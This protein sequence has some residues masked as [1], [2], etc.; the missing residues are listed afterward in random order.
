MAF[1]RFTFQTLSVFSAV[2]V[3]TAVLLM[4]LRITSAVSF[5]EPLQL[6][7]SGWEQETLFPIWKSI[8][9]LV[10]YSDPYKIPFAASFY[11]WLFIEIYAT[12][13]G[14]VLSVLSLEDAWLPTVGRFLTL[15]FLFGGTAVAYG[16]FLQFLK[17][18]D[19]A[20]KILSLSFAVFIFFGPLMGFWGFTVRSDIGALLF[21][22]L[23]VYLF[24]KF[25]PSW[26]YQAVLLCAV[27]AYCAWGFKQV[28]VVS[29]VTIGL[30]FLYQRDWK[31]LFLLAGVLMAAYA[32]TFLIGGPLY[33]RGFYESSRLG[34]SFYQFATNI[35]NFTLKASPYL[36][37]LAALVLATFA[38]PRWRRA[39]LDDKQAIFVLIGLG[40]ATVINLLIS[41]K[42]GSADNY[43]FV[44]SYFIA[45]TALKGYAL[46]RAQVGD[47]ESRVPVRGIVSI[48]ML[49]WAANIVAVAVVLL[50]VKGYMSVTSQHEFYSSITKCASKLPKPVFIDNSYLSLPWMNPAKH[51]FVVSYSYPM[52]R[53]DGL[54]F[55]RGG[56]GGLI[57]EGYFASLLLSKG[58]TDIYDGVG[59]DGYKKLTLQCKPFYPYVRR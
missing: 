50:G 56:I 35:M 41:T 55:E 33:F 18:P 27:A 47:V 34:V 49:G 26:P 16:S 1:P 43:Y 7:T 46:V 45:L 11:N 30:Y 14:A 8:N 10:V 24:W 20:M 17:N 44:L 23:V 22:I 40:S 19:K 2:S 25:Y 37:A 42:V 53:R 31:P 52:D 4:V 51:H 29:T 38:S 13:S 58:D 5:A 28:N 57:D 9:G 39:W 3:A 48:S 12:F 21:E 59:L 54:V 6:T 32:A 15:A 36:A